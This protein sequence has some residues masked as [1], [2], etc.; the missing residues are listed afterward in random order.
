LLVA[1]VAVWFLFFGGKEEIIT[2]RP[3]PSKPFYPA[4]KIEIIPKGDIAVEFIERWQEVFSQNIIPGQMVAVY[5]YDKEVN[6]Y[7]SL[8][9]FFAHVK[10]KAP[11][12]LLRTFKEPWTLGIIGT[13]HG[14]EP[15]IIVPITSFSEAFKGMLE[16]EPSLPAA[17]SPILPKDYPTRVFENFS[18]IIIR[19]QDARTIEGLPGETLFAYSFFGRRILVFGFSVEAQDFVLNYFLTT[20][21]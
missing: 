11:S 7:L 1:G 13:F 10:I 21:P 20:S 16:W 4:D 9:D 18:D 19:N 5:A 8:G 2:T 14:N 17:F 6:N 3:D 12:T 15:I